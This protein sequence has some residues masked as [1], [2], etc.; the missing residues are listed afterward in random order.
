M[1][2]VSEKPVL[3]QVKGQDPQ[4]LDMSDTPVRALHHPGYRKEFPK[5]L[6]G[7]CR[8]FLRPLLLVIPTS[9]SLSLSWRPIPSG[10]QT[11]HLVAEGP[12]DGQPVFFRSD[13][14]RRLNA[15]YHME[16]VNHDP[17]FATLVDNGLKS[18]TD[19]PISTQKLLPGEWPEHY[20]CFERA[21]AVKP[22][23]CVTITSLQALISYNGI[24]TQRSALRVDRV[25]YHPILTRFTQR[26][27]RS[28][29]RLVGTLVRLSI[30]LGLHH[31]PTSQNN[32]FTEEEAQLRIRLWGIVILH[33]RGTSI[34][35]GRPLPIAPSDTNTPHPAPGF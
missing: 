25:L 22:H 3:A 35:L 23:L 30:E 18:P 28:L 17:G 26:Q 2:G 10:L 29:W 34:L 24:C 15:L 5:R 27:G 7:S 9:G 20:E 33:D 16:N 21:L 32:T 12:Q 14:E 4:S 13:F 1:D 11:H 6:R 19:S 8:R 31:D